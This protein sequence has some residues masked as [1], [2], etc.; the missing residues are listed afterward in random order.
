MKHLNLPTVSMEAISYQGRSLLL[1]DLVSSVELLRT[2]PYIDQGA[3][4]RCGL[5]EVIYKRTGIRVQLHLADAFAGYECFAEPPVIDAANPYFKLLKSYG[6]GDEAP[7]LERHQ[8]ALRLAA[9]TLGWVDLKKARVEGVFGTLINRVYLAHDLLND[10]NFTAEEIAS[11]ILH[12]VGHLFSYFE[13]V[14]YTSASNS[15]IATALEALASTEEHTTKVRL[16]SQTLLVFGAVNMDDV[17]T[18]AESTDNT[19]IRALF[20]KT[21]EQ[22]AQI[23]SKQFSQERDTAINTRSIEH[24]AD[25]FAIRNGA[26][27]QLATAQHKL[28]KMSRV[29]DYGRSRVAFLG[30]QAARYGALIGLTFAAPPVGICMTFICAMLLTIDAQDSDYRSDPGERI[31]RIKADLV[32]LLK[33][34]KLNPKLRQQILADVEAVDAV[35]Q[36]AKDYEGVIRFLWRT[37]VPTG[38]RQANL[39]DLQKGMEDLI[40]NDLF[41]HANRLKND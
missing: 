3:L 21:L 27:L 5:A 26:S 40:N 31:G 35:R 23:R 4:D 37:I 14:A 29:H 24:M 33:N 36:D 20:I 25:Q 17:E 32:Q 8:R 30:V 7:V 12:E 18:I 6:L 9:D 41:I 16:V 22:A 11:I 2:A 38:R 39:R 13:T 28:G 10:R 1:F 34:T 15:V 19:V